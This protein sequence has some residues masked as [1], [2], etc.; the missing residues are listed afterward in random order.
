MVRLSAGRQ[1]RLYDG[2]AVDGGA[3]GSSLLLRN[4]TDGFGF[5]N[6][7][8]ND[9]FYFR[10]FTSS[11]NNFDIS[12]GG[13]QLSA[14]VNILTSAAI[15]GEFT[16]VITADTSAFFSAP[17]LRC[18]PHVPR[19]PTLCTQDRRSLQACSYSSLCSR[20]GRK[21]SNPC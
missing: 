3:H 6:S 18:G 4:G 17:T 14:L 15:S 20:F 7:P 8:L 1:R 10:S 9:H 21:I 16:A 2:N 13:G 19:S 12:G 5:L 11:A